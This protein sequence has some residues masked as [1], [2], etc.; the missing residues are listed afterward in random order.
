MKLTTKDLQDLKTKLPR[1]YFSKLKEMTGLSDGTI[2]NFLSGRRY[3]QDI[4][5]AAI[6]L[7]EEETRNLTALQKRQQSIKT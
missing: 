6:I 4:Y 3:R 1:G 7:A 5:Q 2:A